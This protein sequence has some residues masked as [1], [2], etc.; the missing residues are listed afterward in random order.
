M[1]EF[2]AFVVEHSS[3]VLAGLAQSL[4]EIADVSIVATAPDG[5]GAL[6]W[7]HARTDG[8]DIVIPLSTPGRDPDSREM[9]T[10][11]EFAPPPHR[12]VS[13]GLVTLGTQC[14][15]CRPPLPM[16]SGLDR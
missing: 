14:Q 9:S 12:V 2:R 4:E 13:R 5:Q 6:A 15:H 8:C 11:L 10:M 1:A 3:I 16:R 7:T